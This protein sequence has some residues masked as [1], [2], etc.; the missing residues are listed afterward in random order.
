MF[1]AHTFRAAPRKAIRQAVLR[2][3]RGFTDA[4]IPAGGRPGICFVSRGGIGNPPGMKTKLLALAPILFLALCAGAQLPQL[5]VSDNHRFLVKA[6]GS[7]FFYLGDTAWELFHRL[8]REETERYL[9]DRAK[10]GFTVIE[11]VALAEFGGLTQP[12]RYGHLP[13]QDNDPT[14]PQ[15]PYFEHVDWVVNKA[16]SMGLYVGLLPTW[17][18]K[19][20]KKWGQGPE[21]FTPENARVYGAWLGTR[22]RN[23]PVLWILG[24][25]RPIENEKH[26]LIWRA[27]AEGL[28]AGD[29]GAHLITYHPMGGHSSSDYVNDE[30]WLDFHQIQ[31]GHSHRNKDN[32]AM[33]ARDLAKNPPRPVMDGEPC[34]E[35]H[36]VRSDKTKKEWFGEWDVRKLCYWGLFAGAHGHTY[37]CHPI[38]QMWDGKTKP[39]ADPRHSWMEDLDLPGA[40]Q[41]GFARRLIESRPFLTRI[42]DQALITS[43]NPAGPAHVQATRDSEGSFAMVYSASGQ[44]FTADLAKLS[45]KKLRA[46]WFDPRT[47]EAKD[48][49][50]LDNQGP[51]EF[52]PP[53]KGDGNDWVLVLDDASK[54]FPPPG[55]VVR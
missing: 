52:T 48:S 54:Q 35:D 30:T 2:E 41:V 7:P 23:A 51:R 45:A 19:V 9:S 10:K 26:R 17:G 29:G 34:Y 44:P 42:P 8:D 39:C 13:L 38:W 12:N 1:M 22:Y 32:F 47:G 37:G 21:I 11:A 28:R 16:A 46:W 40:S 4:G 18:D 15:E 55:T 53:T 31:S 25:D 49:G 14:R 3:N 20:N 5:R 24:G 50:Q 6:G 43:P 36:P 27:M 33:L